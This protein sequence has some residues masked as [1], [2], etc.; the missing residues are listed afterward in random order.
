MRILI[1]DPSY[2]KSRSD[3][4]ENILPD[5]CGD[6]T[7]RSPSS[8]IKLAIPRR[9]YDSLRQARRPLLPSA[10]TDEMLF[11]FGEQHPLESYQYLGSHHTD[12]GLTCIVKD[13]LYANED[14][15][16]LDWLEVVTRTMDSPN[17]GPMDAS[18]F[19]SLEFLAPVPEEDSAIAVYG[20]RDNDNDN[21][22]DDGYKGL[23]LRAWCKAFPE[24][25]SRDNGELK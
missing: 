15:E 16:E 20:L 18:D 19:P 1:T 13:D 22:N 10:E 7:H 23:V 3:Y 8:Y 5:T 4:D 14:E 12:S 21:D 6:G 17:G 25:E 11:V 24:S 2:I 9:L